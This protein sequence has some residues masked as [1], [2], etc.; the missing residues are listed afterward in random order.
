MSD[1]C[2]RPPNQACDDQEFVT[3]LIA[4]DSQAWCDFMR[5]QG[6]VI[7]AR[8]ADVALSFGFA[9]DAASIDD[10]TAEVFAA[11][12]ERDYA[13]LR[14]Y[15]GRSSLRT[16]LSVISVRC[17]TRQFA[18][19]RL[20]QRRLVPAELVDVPQTIDC[21][22]TSC[23]D[24]EERAQLVA[25]LGELPEKQRD[26]IRLFYLEGQSYSQISERLDMPMG[27]IGVTLKRAEARLKQM[28]RGTNDK[29]TK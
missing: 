4:G 13:V 26:V 25:L 6:C 29:S 8:V 12:L 23:M 18:R 21:E 10:S 3:R 28:I 14:A 15:S 17:A 22:A 27:S 24:A 20:R 1:T 2:Q 16:Y 7:R 5:V 11:I 19:H 9:C